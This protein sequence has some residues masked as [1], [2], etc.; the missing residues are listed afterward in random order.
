MAKED[1]REGLDPLGYYAIL[2]IAP[3]ATHDAVKLAWRKRATDLHPDVN[4]NRDDS[5]FKA[6]GQAYEVLGNPDRRQAYDGMA[7]RFA[8]EQK[9][10]TSQSGG[11][12][13][14]GKSKFAPS[15]SQ[16]IE[17]QCCE[18]CGKVS[19]H[20]CLYVI[21]YTISPILLTMKRAYVGAWCPRCA[22]LKLFQAGLI[23]WLLGWWGLPWGPI[24]SFG[25]LIDIWRGGERPREANAVL[26]GRQALAFFIRGQKDLAANLLATAQ[27]QAQ[28]AELKQ[29]LA[30]MAKEIGPPKRRLRPTARWSVARMATFAPLIVLAI[31]VAPAIAGINWKQTFSELNRPTSSTPI[32][33]RNNNSSTSNARAQIEPINKAVEIETIYV[34]RYEVMPKR[35]NL[36]A[37]PS[38]ADSILRSVAAGQTL[39]D[40]MLGVH[41]DWIGVFLP[42]EDRIYYV[43]SDFLK[44][45]PPLVLQ[46]RNGCIIDDR[47][48]TGLIRAELTGRNEFKVDNG[49]DEDAVVKLKENSQ[50]I[51]VAYVRAGDHGS[52]NN[53]PDGYV[54]IVFAFGNDWSSAC[55]KFTDRMSASAFREKELFRSDRTS[56]SILEVTLHPVIGGN[57]LINQF[58]VENF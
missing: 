6:L 44:I 17:V 14:T 51:F 18:R 1:A 23:T 50:D 24:Y 7:V 21:P 19:A 40:A 34:P 10:R 27:S 20:L 41:D 54:Q 53:V 52:F 4:P 38:T 2:G 58:P 46:I 48:T 22:G 55:D 28:N 9:N 31:F 42:G 8:A 30:A 13:N 56:H 16:S 49:T 45:L 26:Q 11:V 57:A 3:S 37:G 29:W 15:Q 25:C 32:I 5:A 43:H 35:L 33:S 39:I 36:R 12:G 47:P